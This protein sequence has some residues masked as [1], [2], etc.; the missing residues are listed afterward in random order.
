MKLLDTLSKTKKAI[1]GVILILLIMILI[2]FAGTRYAKRNSNPEITSTGLTQQLQEIEEL[3]TMSY[4]YTKV[5]DFSDSLKFNGWHIPLTEKSFLI[6]DDGQFTAGINMD[7]FEIAINSNKHIV[8]LSEVEILSN[9]IDENSIAVYDES[10]N[11]FKPISIN[12]Y[13]TFAKK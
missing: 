1:G 5:G 8:A 11:V 9:E 3:A 12:D 6:T 2:F 4:S 10:K 13:A 7:E